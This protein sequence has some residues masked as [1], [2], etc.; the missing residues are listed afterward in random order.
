ML[1]GGSGQSA[2][3]DVAR[4]A[5]NA[6]SL[7]VGARRCCRL[8][9]LERCGSMHNT[10]NIGAESHSHWER[11]P[12][13][14]RRW[15]GEGWSVR[16]APPMPSASGTCSAG[17]WRRRGGSR[18][19]SLPLRLWSRHPF[20]ALERRPSLAAQ[21]VA[22]GLRRRTSRGYVERNSLSLGLVLGAAESEGG[23]TFRC[24]TALAR[25]ETASEDVAMP[26]VLSVAASDRLYVARVGT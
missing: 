7:P 11:P 13:P 23:T 1:E 16:L 21:L 25:V 10:H 8:A 6:A 14:R 3:L 2:H 24:E 4:L 12:C 17:W 19:P 9:M 18:V 26:L 22:T 15:T 5:S 20:V